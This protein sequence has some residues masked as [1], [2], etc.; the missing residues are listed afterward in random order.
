MSLLHRKPRLHPLTRSQRLLLEELARPLK[1]R[2]GNKYTTTTGERLIYAGLVRQAAKADLKAIREITR[3]LQPIESGMAAKD[4]MLAEAAA[5]Y[6]AS[7]LASL[8]N[9]R[10]NNT[11]APGITPA[12]EDVVHDPEFGVVFL[13]P[14]TAQEKLA[15]DALASCL[16]ELC[17]QLRQ[18]SQQIQSGDRDPV[19]RTQ[20]G[21]L[22]AQIDLA[23]T[24]L[25]RKSMR[26]RTRL[27]LNGD[28]DKV[29]PTSDSEEQ[30]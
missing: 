12:P 17:N 7:A 19:L 24:Y 18:V 9:A 2:K 27:A 3:L 29:S 25:S 20:Q 16:P 13:G 1:A 15:L 10:R 4:A 23:V 30:S 11:P 22:Q 26:E 21:Q 5:N 8:E 14:T 6:R 28:P